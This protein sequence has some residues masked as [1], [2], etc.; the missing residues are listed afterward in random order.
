MTSAPT[1]EA[2]QDIDRRAQ[3]DRRG[4]GRHGRPPGRG[5]QRADGRY[6]REGDRRIRDRAIGRRVLASLDGLKTALDGV[7]EASV[8]GESATAIR[9]AVTEVGTSATA[10]T[11]AIKAGPCPS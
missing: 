10:L 7:G 8:A 5:R 1:S 2:L 6:R 9:A 11:D 3:G 4:H